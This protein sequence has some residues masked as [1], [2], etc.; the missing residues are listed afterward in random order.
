MKLTPMERETRRAER[1][2]RRPGTL[3]LDDGYDCPKCLNRGYFTEV[4]EYNGAPHTTAY[5]CSCMNIRRSL[6]RL[7]RSGLETAIR[8]CTFRNFEVRQP[9]QQKMLDTAMRYLDAGVKE[10]RWLFMGGAV[11]SGKTHICT[12]VAGKLLYQMP[13]IYM[14]WPSD[15]VRLKAIVKDEDEYGREVGRLKS[16]DVLYIDDFFKPIMGD[17]GPL[18]PNSA[19]VRLAYEI[20]NYRYVNRSLTIISSE[21][22]LTELM[23]IDEATASRIAERAKGYTLTLTRDRSKNQRF[24]LA[25]AI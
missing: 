6:Q 12:A 9:W 24:N 11:G 19:D 10:G 25:E 7:K 13:V 14:T 23:D 3:N 18:P 2:N 22:Y 4:T 8:Q 5:E 20:L 16:V 15:S 21:R 17:N 1:E